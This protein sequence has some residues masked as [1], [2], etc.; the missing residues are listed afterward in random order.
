MKRRATTALVFGGSGAVGGEVVRGLVGAGLRTRFT[1]HARAERAHALASEL[2]AHA[3]AVDLTDM[4]AVRALVG[5]LDP[6][7]EV[8]IH[9]AGAG[10]FARLADVTDEEWLRV[11][12]VAC[13]SA[14]VACQALGPRMAERGGGD[15]VLV[16]ALDRSQSLPLP[17][18]F[19][20]SQG[21]LGAMT[22]ALAKELGAGGVR[23]NMVALGPLEEG[24]GQAVSPKLIADYKG[25]SA[26]RRVGQLRE[27]ARAVLWLAL[28]NTYMS[29]R[30][31][32]VNGGV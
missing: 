9:A 5:D 17:V 8:F 7:P 25:F 29:G 15:I 19:A 12:A 22:M 21:M 31:V 24:L 23:V 13:Q 3:Q 1:Y 14:F 26:L 11:Q 10:R 6:T 27:A 28:E 18:H 16:G 4:R 2:G 30:S 20:A 32:P